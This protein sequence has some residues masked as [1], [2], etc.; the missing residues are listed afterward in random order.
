M[1]EVTL[2]RI[3]DRLIHGQVTTAWLRIYPSNTIII[4]NERISKNPMYKSI[5]AATAISGIDILLLSPNDAADYI[6]KAEQEK[7][8]LIITPSPV[9]V[10]ALID[11][12]LK[13][14]KIIVGG[15]QGR[16]NTKKLAK[17]VFATSDEEKAFLELRNRGVE[18]DVQ[19]V[20]TDRITRLELG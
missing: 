14:E 1:G 4:A 16:P 12:G 2:I 20:P 19:M 13:I 17:V 11:A 5:F 15:L 3:D 8:I 7:K 9:D 18:M 10:V 6:K